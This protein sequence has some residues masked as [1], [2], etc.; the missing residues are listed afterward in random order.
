VQQAYVPP[1]HGPALCSTTT[2]RPRAR[3]VD[4]SF[5]PA[6]PWER[7]WRRPSTTC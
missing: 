1:L 6:R 3:V 2:K 7:R 4:R 5:A